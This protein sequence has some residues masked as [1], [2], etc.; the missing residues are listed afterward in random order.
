MNQTPNTPEHK[1]SLTEA[2]E[3]YQYNYTYIPPLAMVDKLPSHEN[4][5]F[6]WLVMVGKQA[7]T[8]LKNTLVAN[9]EQAK[10]DDVKP[11]LQNTLRKT[12]A[13]EGIRKRLNLY[14]QL[15]RFVP[16]IL[17]RNL[18]NALEEVESFLNSMTGLL[19]NDFL[20]PLLGELLEELKQANSQTRATSLEDF[21]QLFQTIELPAIANTFQED[22]VFAYMRVAGANPVMIERMSTVHERLPIT[23]EQYQAVMGTD[24]SLDAAKESGRLY[25][26][27]YSLLAKAINGTYIRSIYPHT[28]IQKYLYSPLALFAVPPGSDPNRM[29]KPVAIQCYSQPGTNNPIITPA[30]GEYAWL[31]AKTVVQ[32]ADTNVHEAVT[33]LARTHLFVG[34]FAIATPR[35]LSNKHPLRLLL[36]PHFQGTLAINNAAQDSL[37][38]PGGGVDSLLS[39][40]IDNSRVLAVLGVQSYGF[41]DAMLPKQLK[42]RGVDDQQQLPVYPYRD[43]ALLIW[44]AIYQWASAY[45]S[46]YY[47]SDE[48]IQQDRELQAWARE[49]TA[50]DGGRVIDFGEENGQIQTREYLIQA[51]TLIIFTASAQHA[52]VNFPQ[53]GL[54][55]YA[56][57]M[58]TAGYIPALSLGSDTTEQ[59]YLN[60]LPPL[61]QAQ[62]QLNLL[63][64]LGSTYFTKLGQYESNHFSDP[65]VQA[66]LQAFQQKLKEIEATIEQRNLTRPAYQYLLP[67]QIPQSINI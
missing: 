51:T 12:L 19:G 45:L 6:P 20:K 66:P 54:M 60:L 4:F 31:I 33:H 25:L 15:V 1:Q 2:R 26:A 39:S 49:L 67:S 57:S 16:Q 64:L 40:T 28:Q 35:Q 13:T 8:L 32:I 65:R 3:L 29:L 11:F 5:S 24:D 34:P 63:Y 43:D 44:E 61:H 52:A 9:G 38:A 17:F 50:F 62:S 41:N 36:E 48:D 56:P 30:T 46:L 42:S 59:D 23:N 14:G 55:S 53:L 27:D 10:E 22:E 7:F 21:N 47:T 18:P 37:I 58:P